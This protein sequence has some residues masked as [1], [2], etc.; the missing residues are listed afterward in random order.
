MGSQR[1]LIGNSEEISSLLSMRDELF[2]NTLQIIDLVRERIKLAAEIGKEKDM[3]GMSPRNR[4]R[5][6]EVLNSIPELG[7]IEKSVLNMI[8]ELTILNEVSQ[9]P[10]VS[11]PESHG[12]NG[13]SIVLSGPDGLLAYSMGLIV[14]FPGFELKDTA[15]IPENLALGVVQRGGHITAEKEGGNSGKITLVNS[16][17]TVMATLDNGILK[18]CPELFSKNSKN[19]IMEAV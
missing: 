10:E 8:F 19:E 7:E 17:G 2:R 3:L 9:R 14:S 6:L 4:Q 15:G 5:E 11:V 12:E 18:I 16:E 1:K 13:G